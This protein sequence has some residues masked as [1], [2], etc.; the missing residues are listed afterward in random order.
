MADTEREICK[1]YIVDGTCG[2]TGACPKQLTET[3]SYEALVIDP[4][5]ESGKIK[6]VKTLCADP[7]HKNPES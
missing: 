6:I 1:Y 5:L 4:S 3:D 7:S 2:F